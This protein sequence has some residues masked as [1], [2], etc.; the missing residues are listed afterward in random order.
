MNIRPT[1]GTQV[2]REV[3]APPKNQTPERAL[4]REDGYRGPSDT[5]WVDAGKLL[6]EHNVPAENHTLM[7]ENLAT[8]LAH[9]VDGIPTK[10][11]ENKIQRELSSPYTDE[12]VLAHV[13][14]LEDSLQANIRELPE[15]PSRVFIT[16]SFAKGRLGANS[17][18]DGFSVIKDEHMTAGFDSYEKRESNPTGSNL[19]PLSE[20]SPGYTKG[21]LMFSGQSVELTPEQIME[22]GSLRKA[23]DKILEGR[24]PDRQETSPSFEWI[25]G[26]LWGEDKTAKE[27]REAFES[28]SLKTR[29]Q[30][31]IM[32]F[33]GTLSETPL[34]GHGV[35]FICDKFATQKHLDF[36]GTQL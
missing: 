35:N 31:G 36:T 9:R 25:T 24:G 26:K 21:H 30:N 28:G 29:I 32:S 27:K 13:D 12:Q 20:N 2:Y 6:R 16:G 10:R 17:D 8:Y 4:V 1:Y 11:W 15:Y 18:L 23:Y 22:D 19:F 7:Q 33:G 5:D 34:I 3:S 14:R